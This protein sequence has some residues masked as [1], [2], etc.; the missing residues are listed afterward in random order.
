MA[1][2]L[3]ALATFCRGPAPVPVPGSSQP[4]VTLVP[5]DPTPP[6]K[7]LRYLHK[8]SSTH[9]FLGAISSPIFNILK[10]KKTPRNKLN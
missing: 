1:H 4:L 5:E 7:I 2:K 8:H 9:T 3:K 6:S 10:V